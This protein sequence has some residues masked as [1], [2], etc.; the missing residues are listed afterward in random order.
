MKPIQSRLVTGREARRKGFEI[1]PVA[2]PLAIIGETVAVMAGLDETALVADPFERPLLRQADRLGR[3]VGGQQRIV[4]QRMQEVGDQQLLVLHLVMAAELGEIVDLGSVGA[5]F[6]QQPTHRLVHMGAIGKHL[7]DRRPR[8]EAAL[9]ARVARPGLDVIGIE[10][11]GE[12]A[13]GCLVA[14]HARLE[15]KLLEEP[16]GMGEVPLGRTGIL[17]RLQR[18]VLRGETLD[19]RV[20]ARAHGIVLADARFG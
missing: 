17:H 3:P 13:V 12:A 18:H 14:G 10:Q 1:G 4:R 16:A 11:E 7:V 20:A 9:G 5:L 8:D 19:Q 15:D 2:R 6:G